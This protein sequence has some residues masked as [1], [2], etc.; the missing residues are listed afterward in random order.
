M[1]GRPARWS[2]EL[3]ALVKRIF[4]AKRAGR[5][6]VPVSPEDARI[7]LAGGETNVWWGAWRPEAGAL[8]RFAGV[9][10]WIETSGS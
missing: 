8:V 7:I 5:P 3:R 6:E 10:A 2:P 9:T 1:K 4:A